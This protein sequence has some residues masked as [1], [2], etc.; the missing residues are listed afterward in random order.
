MWANP[1]FTYYFDL[2]PINQTG[3]YGFQVIFTDGGG[4]N[5][6]YPSPNMTVMTFPDLSFLMAADL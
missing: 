6:L 5:V 1:Y 4:S 3:G 2:I